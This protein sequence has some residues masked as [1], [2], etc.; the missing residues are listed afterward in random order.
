M[1]PQDQTTPTPDVAT[2][3]PDS[4]PET[5]PTEQPAPMTETPATPEADAAALQAIEALEADTTTAAPVTP[6]GPEQQTPS[7]APVT[8]SEPAHP[9]TSTPPIT[10]S[11]P[12]PAPS[13]P[14]EVAAAGVAAAVGAQQANQLRDTASPAPT[15]P[16]LQPAS[17]SGQKKS[18]SKRTLTLVAIVGV[19]VLVGAGL[20]IWQAMSAKNPTQESTNTT[21]TTDTPT[22]PVTGGDLPSGDQT[23]VQ[24]GAG[25]Q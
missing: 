7:A 13:A 8:E 18:M 16:V 12:D 14:V 1:N 6:D 17:F 11:Q 2:T 20:L 19:L 21:Q 24:S 3:P 23:T 4:I 9:I 22:E 25:T 5:P 15:T 10:P